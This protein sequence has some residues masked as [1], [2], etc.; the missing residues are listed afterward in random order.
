MDPQTFKTMGAPAMAG[1]RP[2][3]PSRAIPLGTALRAV[4]RH[5][6]ADGCQFTLSGA[7]PEEGMRMF[8]T[9]RNGGER[10]AGTVRWVLAERIGFAFDRPL[11]PPE[12][13]EMTGYFEASS[14]VLL[15]P[16]T[17]ETALP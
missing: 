13:A 15:R 6:S 14:A 3:V 10:V 5:V 17:D 16:C 4:A 8:F 9:T 1:L 2:G 12:L 7:L 11:G